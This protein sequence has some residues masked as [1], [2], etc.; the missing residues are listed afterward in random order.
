MRRF[1]KFDEKKGGWLKAAKIFAVIFAVTFLVFRF[2]I[3][4]SWV[5]GVSMEPT[6]TD[7]TGVVFSRLTRQYQAGDIVCVRMAYGEYYIK[8]VAAVAGDVVEL[9]D[10]TA[11]VNGSSIGGGETLPQSSQVV[12][13]L[14]IPEGRYFLLGDNRGESIDSRTFGPVA[15][16]QILGKVIF[17]LPSVRG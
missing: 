13:P 1:R 5:S 2:V 11:L 7:G 14:T 10:G 8:R 16:S 12:Y 17:T 4:V 6:L 15:K 3:G 9:A